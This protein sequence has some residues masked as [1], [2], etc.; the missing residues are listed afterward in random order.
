MT[1]ANKEIMTQ[2]RLQILVVILL[3][4][5]GFLTAS[6]IRKLRDDFSTASMAIQRESFENLVR[7]KQNLKDHSP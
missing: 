7:E 1:Q 5:A 6:F 2:G 3:L 4:L